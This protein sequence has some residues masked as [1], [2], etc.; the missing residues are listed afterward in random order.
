MTVAIEREIKLGFASVDEARERVIAS[1]ATPLRGRRLQEDAL[2]D[3]PD[4]RLRR[5]GCVLRIRTE[6]GK[7]RI[8]FKGPVHAGIMKVRDEIETSVGD[9]DAVLRILDASGFRPWFR[10]QKYREEYALEDVIIAIDETPV[11]I[12]VELEG[13]ENGIAAVAAVLGRAEAD[14]LRDSYRSLFVRHCQ[15]HGC[16]PGDML[17][18]VA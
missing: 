14:Y 2:L 9:A 10:Y 11:G 18:D 16:A 17:F 3:T 4:E 13:G 12:Y 5:A 7:N 6:S 1:G 8:T 15:E